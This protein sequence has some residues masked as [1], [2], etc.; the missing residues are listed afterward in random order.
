MESKSL[1]HSFIDTANWSEPL[2][3]IKSKVKVV[4]SELCKSHYDRVKM[5]REIDTIADIEKL[6]RYIFNSLLKFEGQGVTSLLPR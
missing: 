1:L 6:Q 4:V 2:D 5:L 3:D